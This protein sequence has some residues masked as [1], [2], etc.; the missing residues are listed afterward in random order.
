MNRA[1]TI[2]AMRAA[3]IPTGLTIL[4]AS[5][6]TLS[7]ASPIRS[8][9]A[10][11]INVTVVAMDSERLLPHRTVL[12]RDGYIDAV[13]P[14]A[15]E[16]VPKECERIDGR[17]RYLILG[18]T[19]SHAHFFG[20]MKADAG[21]VD[22]EKPILRMFLANGVTTIAVMEGTPATLSLRDDVSHG[23]IPGPRIYSAG[24]LIQMPNSGAPF[25]RETFM[26]PDDVRKEVIAEKLAGYD[27]IKVH[28]DL[29]AETYAA[30]LETA[31][32]QHIRVVGHVPTNLGINAALNGVQAMIAH[33][34]ALPPAVSD[35]RD[36]APRCHGGD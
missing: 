11:F 24:K 8:S 12:V 1:L 2:M 33:A 22:A 5:M 9:C 34:P 15:T 3:F 17:N 16:A 32:Q 23:R 19:D 30:L 25:G 4:L 6:P 26:T 36:D 20:Y 35:H 27:F 21:D 14:V 13:A 29:P 18:L 10:A 7:S 28:G 31:R